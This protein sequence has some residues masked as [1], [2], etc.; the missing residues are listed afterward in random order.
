MEV[1]VARQPIFDRHKNVIGYEL[2]YRTGQVD[3]FDMINYDS[4][5]ASVIMNSFITIGIEK[6]TNNKC[7]YIKFTDT[8]LNYDIATLFDKNRIVIEIIEDF[9]TNTDLL[10]KCKELKNTGYKIVLDD[11]LLMKT[12]LP[13]NVIEYIDIVKVDFLRNSLIDREDIAKEMKSIGKELLAERV[14]TQEEFNEAVNMGYDYFQGYFFC[15]PQ[16]TTEKDI[17]MFKLNSLHV[18]NELNKTEPEYDRIAEIIN[19]DISLTYKLLRLINS[20]AFHLNEQISDIK[21]ALVL[22]GFNEIR[23]FIYL[24]L[25]YDMC[26]DKPDELIRLSLMRAKFGEMIFRNHKDIKENEV[27]LM[28]MFSLIDAVLDK[29]LDQALSLLPLSDKAKKALLGEKNNYY[30]IHSLIVSYEK[31]R[32]EDFYNYLYILKIDG[33][34]I[35]NYYQASIEWVN[36]IFSSWENYY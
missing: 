2:F 16:I 7:A 18:I 4:A 1:Y 10:K 22:L 21:H 27:F 3:R 9:V 36:D 31:N 12:D 20:A 29:P 33:G 19:K 24:V 5:S 35:F 8:L 34:N 17:P 11:Y 23:K 28:E 6:L 32:W 15:K 13:E 14:E 26:K 30:Y 25:L